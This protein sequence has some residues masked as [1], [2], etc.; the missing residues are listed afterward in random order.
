MIFGHMNSL[1]TTI[2]HS[3][4]MYNKNNNIQTGIQS[5]KFK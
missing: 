5:L 1:S 2:N 4:H 3:I